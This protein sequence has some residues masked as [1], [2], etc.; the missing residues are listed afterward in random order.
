MG[1]LLSKRSSG[2]E[3]NVQAILG[4][5]SIKIAEVADTSAYYKHTQKWNGVHCILHFT[6]YF[7]V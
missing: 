3:A 1:H 5:Q 4:R 7:H 6:G 2:D